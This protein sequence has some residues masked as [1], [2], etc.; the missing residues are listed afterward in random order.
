MSLDWFYEDVS[1]L[2]ANF[3]DTKKEFE[4]TT[5]NLKLAAATGAVDFSFDGSSLHGTITPADGPQDF[6][7][8]ARK[9]I[10]LRTS[11]AGTMRVWAWNNG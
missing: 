4:G 2:T 6:R 11:A 8:M 10:Y 5:E 9:K 1:G 7:G 3:V